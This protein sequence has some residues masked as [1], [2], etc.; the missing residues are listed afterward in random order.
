ML[1][2]LRILPGHRGKGVRETAC[3]THQHQSSP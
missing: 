2:Q 3:A 1:A